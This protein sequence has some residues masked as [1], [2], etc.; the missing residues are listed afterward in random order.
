[1][2]IL[3]K[4]LSLF[5][6]SK[7]EIPMNTARQYLRIKTLTAPKTSL[8]AQGGIIYAVLKDVDATDAFFCLLANDGGGYFSREVVPFSRVQGCLKG[9]KTDQ[10]IPAKT[11]KDAFVGRSVNNAG[12]LVAA[13]RREGLL[14]PAPDA[15]HQHVM[16]RNW[17]DWKKGVLKEAGEAF[18]LPDAK[19]AEVLPAAPAM[20]AEKSVKEV[21]VKEVPVKRGKKSRPAIPVVAAPVVAI[22]V[23]AAPEEAEPED[24]DE[25]G[26]DHACSA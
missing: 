16:G 26:A 23:V 19:K 24:A 5:G 21:P 22:P 2:V 20:A 6:L 15:S 25:E 1:L 14:R 9:V 7:K 13:L 10:P 17:E 4:A 12:F 3:I 18:A 11:F 8:Y